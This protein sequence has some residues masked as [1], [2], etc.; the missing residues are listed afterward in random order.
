MNGRGGERYPHGALIESGCDR[1][2]ILDPY[3]YGDTLLPD[4]S[5][6]RSLLSRHKALNRAAFGCLAVAT[7]RQALT[8]VP[9]PLPF[10]A[11]SGELLYDLMLAVVAGWLFHFVVVVIPEDQNK[12]RLDEVAAVRV[13]NLLRQ[14][15]SLARPL[16]RAARVH[17]NT[18][19]LREE[20]V[21]QACAKV[22]TAEAS[23]PGWAGTWDGLLRH[24]YRITEIQRTTLRPLY[25]R[26]DIELVRL[27]DA[28]ELAYTH[29][30]HFAKRDS[31]AGSRFTAYAPYMST[32]LAAIEDLRNFRATQMHVEAP[33]PRPEDDEPDNKVQDEIEAFESAIPASGSVRGPRN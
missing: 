32:W 11:V 23:P 7:T 17:P 21:L 28:E 1:L 33:P 20:D 15:Y 30:N 12:R 31:I 8:V 16:A 5:Q 25:G 10:M 6:L 22:G 27:L 4:S 14:G 24:L 13:D 29:V 19:P 26:L 9:E 3:T 2:V 18:W